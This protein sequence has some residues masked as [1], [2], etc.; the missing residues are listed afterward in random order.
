MRLHR[1][2]K[3]GMLAL[4]LGLTPV[5]AQAL[6]PNGQQQFT[7]SNGAPLA[8]GSVYFYY[9]GTT[10][11]KTTWQDEGETTPNT[12]PVVLNAAG[13]AQIWGSGLYREIVYDANGNLIFDAVTGSVGTGSG[14]FGATTSLA[15]SATTDLGTVSSHNVIITGTT[16]I[17]SFGSSASSGSPYYV[18]EFANAGLQL[19][20]ST[21][22][23]L[24]GGQNITTQAGDVAYAMYLGG[25]IWQVYSYQRGNGQ[26]LSTSGAQS[27]LASASTTDL[28]SVAGNLISI[29]GTTTIS[30]FGSSASTANP[31]YWLYFPSSLTL[32]NSSALALPGG[33]NITTTA[34]SSALAEYLGSGNWRVLS[35]N[36]SSGSANP[37]NLHT[38]LF[39]SSGSFT[40]PTGTSTATVYQFQIVSG[41]GGGGGVS[42][43]SNISAGGGGSGGAEDVWLSGFTPG[44][45]VT[46]TVGAG[47]AG[48][49]N[50]GGNGGSGTS[51][52][53]SYASVNVVSCTGGGGGTGNTAS[54]VVDGGGYGSCTVGVG[55]SGLTLVADGALGGQNGAPN[56]NSDVIGGKGGSDPW[57]EGGMPIGQDY[58]SAGQGYGAG[59][60]GASNATT[61]AH[62]GG[63]GTGGMVQVKWI[64]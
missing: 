14:G 20:N 31:L 41:G 3:F 11:A 18:L 38:Q 12:D 48:G 51:S 53:I 45:T 61:T 33:A 15:S 27:T 56:W 28:G 42:S 47:G 17:S 35:Y 49:N 39:T 55:S 29:S 2:L 54:G 21:Y 40:V 6:L 16:A 58:V 22:L 26:A 4:V 36:S 37:T 1:V 8:N 9:P 50:S 57:G 64:Q 59:G 10:T 23:V 43:T 32:T 34:G 13:R 63:S 52:V 46:I 30:S 62:A 25:G 60:S 24:P 19:T 44:Q 5:L 7:D